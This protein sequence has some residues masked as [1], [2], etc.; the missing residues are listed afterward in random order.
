MAPA[1]GRRL[2]PSRPHGRRAAG[3]DGALDCDVSGLHC[4]LGLG[5]PVLLPPR[6]PST[7]RHG[8]HGGSRVRVRGRRGCLRV[9]KAPRADPGIRALSVPPL[10]STRSARGG[11]VATCMTDAPAFGTEHYDKRQIR[12]VFERAYRRGPG[13]PLVPLPARGQ[14]GPS[15]RA[16]ATRLHTARASKSVVTPPAR[17]E[18]RRGRP[19][20]SF[21]QSVTS[22]A[23]AGPAHTGASTKAGI[24]S[25]LGSDPLLAS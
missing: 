12:F 8:H 23:S 13:V 6:P 20:C 19:R 18:Q 3:R 5:P 21:R 7:R 24:R 22:A 10:R 1:L 4:G 17:R 25:S 11:D 15:S 2:A 14:H 16:A 9:R